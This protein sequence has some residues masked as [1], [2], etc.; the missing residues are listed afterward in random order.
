MKLPRLSVLFLFFFTTIFALSAEENLLIREIRISNVGT[1]PLDEQFVL[2]H[3]KTKTG[4]VIDSSLISSDIKRL[5][6][7]ERFSSVVTVME[8]F[9][10]GVAIV[11]K[12]EPRQRFVGKEIEIEGNEKLSERKIH[13]LVSIKTGDYIDKHILDIAGGKV[14]EEYRS[15]KRMHNV[16]FNWEIIP[17]DGVVNTGNVL[18]KLRIS[19]GA[20]YSFAGISVEG[21]QN[22]PKSQLKWAFSIRS[23]WNPVG[24]F[25]RPKFDSVELLS[26]QQKIVTFYR[27]KG[28]LDAQ[29]SV[30]EIE[31]KAD[32]TFVIKL[33]ISEGTSYRIGNVGISGNKLFPESEL[34]NF[35]KLKSSSLASYSDIQQIS[36][37]IR[38]FYGSRG[39]VNTSVKAA[40]YPTSNDLVDITYVITEGS[41][42][43]IRN[44]IIRGNHRTKDKVIRREVLVYPGEIYNEVKIRT[45]ER[46]L[47]NLGYFEQV[48]SYPEATRLPDMQDLVFEVQEKRTGQFMIGAGFSSVDKMMGFVEISQGNFDIKGWPYFTG[49]GQKLNLRA[50]A[51]TRRQDYSISFVEPWLFDYSLSFGLDLYNSKYSYTEYDVSKQGFALSL[52]KSLPFANRVT[53][54]YRLEETK[55]SDI[56]DTNRYVFIDDESKEFYFTRDKQ[57]SSSSLSLSLSHDT[58][59]NP[60][61]PTKGV[62]ASVFGEVDGG[63]LGADTDIYRLGAQ[64]SWYF[65]LWFKHVISLRVKYETVDTFAETEEV[66]IDERLFMG[67]GRTLRGFQYRDVGPKV[68]YRYTDSDGNLHEQVRSAGGLSM[69]MANA[70]YWIPVVKGIRLAAFFDIG[71][72]WMDPFDFRGDDM[73]YSTGVGIRFDI[74]G[75]PIRIDRGWILKK[76]DEYTDEDKFVFWVGYDF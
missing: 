44:V 75:F 62:K 8:P 46:R 41:L 61:V 33:R 7:T 32:K 57:R 12:V 17:V 49:G 68:A 11:F 73:A 66:P 19:E 69:A 76:D 64:S 9:S 24:W 27:E 18:L 15:R 60:F 43:N 51:G 47:T 54:T 13:S 30:P 20:K 26:A 67:G 21:A 22:I 58:R 65:P 10:N 14:V 50:Q 72:A 6:A 3:I 29:V 40:I 63:I 52:G 5:L 35:L 71:N 34:K 56:I 39:Y 53:L 55:I 38:D 59:N 25:S 42:M 2:S 31:Y 70:E 28:F 37:N 16:S 48:R 23:W 36:Q 4:S 1:V 74:P 45:S